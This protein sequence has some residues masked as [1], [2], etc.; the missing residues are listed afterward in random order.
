MA[1]SRVIR[2]RDHEP[3]RVTDAALTSP[4]RAKPR[5]LVFVAV[6]LYCALA[7]VAVFKLVDTGVTIARGSST[8]HYAE[9]AATRDQ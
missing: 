3:V 1:L 5:K 9:S 7:W 2:R 6:A 8:V 4:E